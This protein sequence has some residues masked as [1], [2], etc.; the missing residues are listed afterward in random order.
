GISSDISLFLFI[1]IFE[2]YFLNLGTKKHNALINT[3]FCYLIF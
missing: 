3:V 2:V 1:F